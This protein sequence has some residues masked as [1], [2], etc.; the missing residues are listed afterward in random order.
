MIQNQYVE[1][2]F[3]EEIKNRFLCL[4]T[5]EGEDILCYI[6]SSC[7]LSNF[8][9]MPGRKVLLRPIASEKSRT[10]YSVFAVW[11]KRRYI[12]VNLSNIN[13]V[14][15]EQINRRL[16]SKLGK[17]K[18]VSKETKIEGYKSDLYIADT[19]TLVEIKCILSFEEDAHFPTIYSERAVNQLKQLVNLLDKGYRVCYIFVSLNPTVKKL[20]INPDITDYYQ[21]FYEGIEKGMQVLG[22]T[23]GFHKGNVIS[24][25]S[26]LDVQI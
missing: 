26:Q 23:A 20:K 15:Y 25:D 8:M 24:V 16:F 17:R 4:V 9:E 21:L 11:T 22:F 5:V 6:P 2:V 7:R 3:K 12:P 10:K 14:V 13:T 19:N 18:R 1:G